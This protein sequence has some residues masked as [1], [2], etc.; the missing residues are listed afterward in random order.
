MM[1]IVR[2]RYYFRRTILHLS[3]QWSRFPELLLESLFF[4]QTRLI[5][6]FLG[7]SSYGVWWRL[8]EQ[9]EDTFCSNAGKKNYYR[10]LRSSFGKCR[11]LMVDDLRMIER[12]AKSVLKLHGSDGAF[13]KM[14]DVYVKNPNLL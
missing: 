12:L 7:H 10:Y 1:A 8:G 6:E 11:A 4:C 14:R 9:A 3:K 2:S 5:G 13:E